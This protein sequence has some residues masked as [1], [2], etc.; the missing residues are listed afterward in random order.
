MS[1]PLPSTEILAFR[2]P[3]V[4][5]EAVCVPVLLA[6]GEWSGLHATASIWRQLLRDLDLTLDAR[7]SAPQASHRTFML[8]PGGHP[9]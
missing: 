4:K 2:E 6:N 8:K 1:N 5:G 3:I 9:L 7:P